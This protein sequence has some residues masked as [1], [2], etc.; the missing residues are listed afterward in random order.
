MPIPATCPECGTEYRLSD[1][2]RGQRICC[3][4]CRT[5]FRVP[6][7]QARP[8]SVQAPGGTTTQ[9][10]RSRGR[11]RR[12]EIDEPLPSVKKRGGGVSPLVWILGGVALLFL[13]L[14]GICAGL[15][16]TITREA[17][18]AADEFAEKVKNQPVME[19]P[20][21]PG[22]IELFPRQPA[23]L[24]EAL[25]QLKD[26]EP[27]RRQSAASWIARHR[28][29]ARRRAETARALEPLLEDI[30]AGPRVA[31]MR[32]LEKWGDTENV[33]ALI[34][35]LESD[36]GGFEGDECRHR[37]TDMIVRLKDARAA[38]AIARNFKHPFERE[39][40]RRALEALG[41]PAEEAVW[42]YL[43]DQDWGVRVE[44]CRTLRRI[45]TGRSLP[46]LQQ[47]LDGTRAMYGGYRS[48][49]DSAREAIDAINARP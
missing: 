21:G 12:D 36:P 20:P 41:P 23:N 13:T 27:G 14:V 28:V 37:A 16:Y 22:G 10:E 40:T 32:A 48:V 2:E 11:R 33:P 46:R 18:R 38:A 34:R 19:M 42:P 25:A 35:L 8:T 44:A 5:T 1:A 39:Q 26:H 31:A 45:G 3:T 24:D 17:G 7:P 49:A 4:Q 47:T 9:V 30:H 43:K 15:I 29:E 6:D